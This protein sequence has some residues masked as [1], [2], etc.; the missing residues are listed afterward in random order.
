MKWLVN[1]V[2]PESVGVFESA[3]EEEGSASSW[4]C[5]IEIHLLL[6]TENCGLVRKVK[7]HYS[8]RQGHVDDLEDV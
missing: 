3:P 7:I 5:K 6:N 2:Q 8:E 4:P 1:L